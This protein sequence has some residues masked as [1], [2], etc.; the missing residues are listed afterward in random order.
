MGAPHAY[1]LFPHLPQPFLFS[2]DCLSY[3][4]EEFPTVS[5][6]PLSSDSNLQLQVLVYTDLPLV[7]VLVQTYLGFWFKHINIVSHFYWE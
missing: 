3:F 6:H 7:P 5:L 2:A 1:D 4:I